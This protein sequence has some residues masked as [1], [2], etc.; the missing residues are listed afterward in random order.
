MEESLVFKKYFTSQIRFYSADD[1]NQRKP[2]L[3]SLKLS[4][5]FMV[6]K[7]DNLF[8]GDRESKR[9]PVENQFCMQIS[10]HTSASL[11]CRHEK[12]NGHREIA[13]DGERQHLFFISLPHSM[14]DT[15]VKMLRWNSFVF[16]FLYNL[17]FFNS[18]RL[19]RWRQQIIATQ[20]QLDIA[21]TSADEWQT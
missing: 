6:R 16:T 15:S 17:T 8:L 9:A 18:F 1:D 11:F 14:I 10:S 19:F 7:F 20:H 12:W 3:S 21:E 2:V 4:V 13:D 5:K